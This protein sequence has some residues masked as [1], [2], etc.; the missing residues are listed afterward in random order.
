MVSLSRFS[1]LRV[2]RVPPRREASPQT[3]GSV[4]L[5]APNSEGLWRPNAGGLAWPA[6][7]R[8]AARQVWTAAAAGRRHARAPRSDLPPEVTGGVYA[9]PAYLRGSAVAR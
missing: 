4:S 5:R 8:D 1:C 3:A 9:E 2:H 6:C 7:G